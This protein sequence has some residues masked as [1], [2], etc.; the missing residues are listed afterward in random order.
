MRLNRSWTFLASLAFVGLFGLPAGAAEPS[1]TDPAVPLSALLMPPPKHDSAQTKAELQELLRLQE[2]RTPEQIKHVK[3]DDLRTLERFLG[4]IG[5]KVENLSGSARHFFDCIDSSVRHEVHEAKNT[6]DRTRP[7][8]LP[9]N[10]LNTL[11][12]LSDRDSPSYPSAHATYGAA[13]GMVLA[14][15]IP[16]KKEAIYKRIQDYG[17]SRIVS[18]AHFR[19]DVY[20]GNVAGA[21][22]AA[23]LL[24]KETFRNELNEV[25]AELRKAAGLAP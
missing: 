6:F 5:I 13:L 14:E 19:S 25:K 16:E 9:H 4:G 10:N 23:S 22:I 20:A 3:E 17:H 2:S 8:R 21:A 15:M 7:Y 24:S 11:K 12:K 18:G 1:C